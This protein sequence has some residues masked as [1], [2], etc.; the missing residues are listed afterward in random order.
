MLEGNG[1]GV[2]H[3]PVCRDELATGRLVPVLAGHRLP[4]LPVHAIYPAS[5]RVP[6]KTAAVVAWLQ[7][8]LPA[9]LDED[10]PTAESA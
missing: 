4:D 8:Q 1:I 9:L 6:A 2:L 10:A 5:R 3:R 7:T